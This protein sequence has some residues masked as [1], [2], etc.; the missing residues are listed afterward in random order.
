MTTGECC[1]LHKASWQ[2]LNPH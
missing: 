1:R 2:I